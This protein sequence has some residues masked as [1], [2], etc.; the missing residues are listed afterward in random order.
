M[1]EPGLSDSDTLDVFWTITD[2]CSFPGL[3]LRS[4]WPLPFFYMYRAIALIELFVNSPQ[5]VHKITGIGT[6]GDFGRH[7]LSCQIS[8]ILYTATIGENRPCAREN[9]ALHELFTGN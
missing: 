5:Q 9:G 7:I 1:F 3:S 2:L 6:L 8:A 4:E